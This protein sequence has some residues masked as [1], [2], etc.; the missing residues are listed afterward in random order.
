M[1]DSVFLRRLPSTD[2]GT[3]G[4]LR[5]GDNICRTLELPW[6]DNRVQLSCIPTG[7]YIIRW[8]RSNRF[9]LC[10]HVLGVLGRSSVLIHSA[11]FAGDSTLGFKTEL[12]GCISLCLRMGTMDGQL[13]GL[14][15]RPAVKAFEHW[16]AG[17]DLL[18]EIS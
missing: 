3:P 9:G 18:L 12:H 4:R 6:R 17:R 13:A 14:V 7:S 1:L 15:S 10:Y 5:F 8:K 16:G 11:N 2:Q